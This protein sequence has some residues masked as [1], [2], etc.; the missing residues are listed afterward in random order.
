M[1][2]YQVTLTAHQQLLSTLVRDNLPT[3]MQTIADQGGNDFRMDTILQC[4]EGNV[5]NLL[6]GDND[7]QFGFIT[8]GSSASFSKLD[9]NHV[10]VRGTDGDLLTII[11]VI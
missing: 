8:P 9:L 1:L 7:N 10:Y 2:N 11:F 4:P 6:F 5:G 3:Y